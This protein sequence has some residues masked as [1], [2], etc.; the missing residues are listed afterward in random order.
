ML[1]SGLAPGCSDGCLEHHLLEWTGPAQ[2]CSHS[3]KIY[4]KIQTSCWVEKAAGS[5]SQLLNPSVHTWVRNFTSEVNARIYRCGKVGGS[6]FSWLLLFSTEELFVIVSP[7]GRLWAS[8]CW[9]DSVPGVS[10]I[11][12]QHQWETIQIQV[13][14]DL[15]LTLCN[16][17]LAVTNQNTTCNAIWTF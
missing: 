11:L 3:Q 12:P 16:G 15:L 9:S 4:Q 17:N 6:T 14:H 5:K 2:Q 8:W 1:K 10:T 7:D 13:M